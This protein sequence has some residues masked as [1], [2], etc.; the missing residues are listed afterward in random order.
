LQS[1]RFIRAGALL[2]NLNLP[3]FVSD[4]DLLLQREVSDLLQ[5]HA[6]SDLVLNENSA[7]FNAGS[8]LTANLLLLN[9]TE[10]TELFLQYL[11]DYLE[12]MLARPEVSRWIDQLGLTAARHHLIIRVPDARMSYFDTDTDINNVMYRS[13]QKHPFRFLSLYHGFDTSSLE[14]DAGV[15]GENTSGKAPGAASGQRAAA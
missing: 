10:N 5:K 1:A 3:I 13:Y 14:K 2:R 15:L 8:R 4:I 11:R 12:R 6:Q 7:S 9:P